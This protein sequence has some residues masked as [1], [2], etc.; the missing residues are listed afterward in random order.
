MPRFRFSLLTLLLLNL[1]AASCFLLY[2]RM[3]QEPWQIEFTYNDD[4]DDL[5]E[6]IGARRIESFRIQFKAASVKEKEDFETAAAAQE[7]REKANKEWRQ[8]H[9]DNTYLSLEPGISVQKNGGETIHLNALLDDVSNN[10]G[11]VGS[12]IFIAYAEYDPTVDRIFSIGDHRV[13]IWKPTRP[14][15]WLGAW[16]LPE[17]WLLAVFGLLTALNFWRDRKIK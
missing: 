14:E 17:F 2:T 12:T 9:I 10:N 1:C 16:R 7:A 8:F 6:L 13:R 3:K 15:S 5:P 11:F 4:R